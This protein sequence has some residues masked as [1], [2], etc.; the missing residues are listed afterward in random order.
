MSEPNSSTNITTLMGDLDGGVFEQKIGRALSDVAMGILSTGKKG[1]VT[2]RFDM[3]QISESNQVTVSHKLTFKKPTRRGGVNEE[4][5]TKTPMHVG[6]G[7]KL[8]LMPEN[9]AA[10]EFMK[11][12]KK[13]TAGA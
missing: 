11:A 3:E 10:F 2:V 6:R 8:S 4:D 13:T 12:S 7:G 1:F 9:Q 5:T